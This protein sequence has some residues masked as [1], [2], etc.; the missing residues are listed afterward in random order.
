MN[1]FV[2]ALAMSL[3]V[4]SGTALTA[5]KKNELPTAS[6]HNTTALYNGMPGYGR[7]TIGGYTAILYNGSD[8][9][10]VDGWDSAALMQMYGKNVVADHSS[11]GFSVL[12]GTGYGT[13]ATIDDGQTTYFLTCTGNYQASNDGYDLVLSDG[14]SAFSNGSGNWIM[15]TCN[16]A[17]G[18]SVTVT[19]WNITGSQASYVAP[20]PQP[21]A[22][23]Q[24]IVSAPAQEVTYSA[25]AQQQTASYS[26]P[27]E[28]AASAQETKKEEKK[29][30]T[31]DIDAE[32]AVVERN[33]TVT[34]S[35]SN[36]EGIWTVEN[37]NAVLT[38]TEDGIQFSAKQ[39]GTYTVNYTANGQTVSTEVKV[40][41]PLVI[42]DHENILNGNKTVLAYTAGNEPVLHNVPAEEPGFLDSFQTWYVERSPLA[43]AINYIA[44]NF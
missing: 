22:P 31:L 1:G 44:E 13:Q 33:S 19:F 36:D 12:Y 11:D 16:D 32:S 15:Y 24:E 29:E 30:E 37:N 26:A 17:A 40:V 20:A 2:T 41:E 18:V 7:L 38:R 6:T 23:V 21:A 35:A 27:A 39:N 9:S 14:S 5:E 8:Q 4:T 10:I 25:P 34:L 43:L 42:E 3:A 28:K